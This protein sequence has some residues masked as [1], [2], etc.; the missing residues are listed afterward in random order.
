M[1]MQSKNL[2]AINMLGYGI[3]TVVCT[4]QEKID[5]YF[6]ELKSQP[7]KKFGNGAGKQV[8]RNFLFQQIKSEDAF[9]TNDKFNGEKYASRWYEFLEDCIAF[10]CIDSYMNYSTL[11]IVEDS[12]IVSLFGSLG[13]TGKINSTTSST[14]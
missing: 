7:D 8:L 9:F 13:D 12:H 5:W 11:P 2:I 14:Y 1:K 3:S 10:A 4:T 6:N